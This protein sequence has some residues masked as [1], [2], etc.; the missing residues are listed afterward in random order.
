M[1]VAAF[2]EYSL[3]GAD[4]TPVPFNMSECMN[5]RSASLISQGCERQGW[6]AKSNSDE[7]P[8]ETTDSFKTASGLVM[9]AA[10]CP[11]FLAQTHLPK[12]LAQIKAAA[13]FEL[14]VGCSLKKLQTSAHRWNLRLAP[15]RIKSLRTA[16]P[17]VV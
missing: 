2:V 13:E 10:G 14:H 3:A 5:V 12:S 4:T 7:P 11:V 1:S 6:F 9:H 17:Q 15:A 16:S 8:V